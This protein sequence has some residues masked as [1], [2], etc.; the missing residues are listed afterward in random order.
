MRQEGNGINEQLEGA[1]TRQEMSPV[2]K[3]ILVLPGQSHAHFVPLLPGDIF[4][5]PVLLGN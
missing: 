2:N 1:V 4:N 3:L 5:K